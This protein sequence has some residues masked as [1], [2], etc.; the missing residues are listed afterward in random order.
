VRTDD[1]LMLAY[2]GGEHAAFDALFERYR[3]PI[4]RFFR[5]RIPDLQRAEELTQ[6][7]F[8]AVVRGARRYEPRSTFRSYLFGIAFNV[9]STSRRENR[10]E[11]MAPLDDVNPVAPGCDATAV[12]WVRRALAELDERDRDVL[13]LR[14]YDQL[15]YDEIA[16]LTG[17]VV[18]TVRSRLFRARLALKEKLVGPVE[19]QGVPR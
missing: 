3:D 10:R 17:V 11:A 2:R 19:P 16:Q 5:R 7:T 13:M 6:D 15:S 1:E 14:E 8:L 9:L 12:L 18:G 4:W